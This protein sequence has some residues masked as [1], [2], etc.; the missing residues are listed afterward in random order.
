MPLSDDAALLSS[1][2][3]TPGDV[4]VT[5]WNDSDGVSVK[6]SQEVIRISV[7]SSVLLGERRYRD[8]RSQHR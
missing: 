1:F 5:R 3:L 2:G 6:I 7:E 4:V 8:A